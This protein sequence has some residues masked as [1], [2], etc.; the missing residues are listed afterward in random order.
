[1]S[2]RLQKIII[3]TVL[4]IVLFL[5]LLYIAFNSS[6]VQTKLTQSIGNYFGEKWN[7]TVSLD[8]IHL[9][10]F[11]RLSLREVYIEDLHGDTMIYASEIYINFN[12]VNFFK[13]VYS[14]KDLRLNDAR[15]YLK[16][17]KG[18]DELNLA[19]LIKAFSSDQNK[20]TSKVKEPFRLSLDDVE[21]NRTHFIFQNQNKVDTGYGIHYADLD[22]SGIN[23]LLSHISIIDDSIHFHIESLNAKEKSG[24]FLEDIITQ[25]Y[26]NGKGFDLKP[27][28]INMNNSYI[29]ANR[30]AFEYGEWGNFVDFIDKV[31]MIGDFNIA[32]ILMDDIAYFAPALVGWE[33]EFKLEGKI[34]GKVNNLSGRRI[35]IKTGN[36]TSFHGNFNIDGLPD[37]KTS[38]ITVEANKLYSDLEDLENIQ[39]YPFKEGKKIQLPE[40][41][42]EVGDFTFKG[43]FT[44]FLNDF[45]SYGV[46][47]SK[48]GNIKS[49]VSLKQL[50]NDELLFSGRLKAKELDLGTIIGNSIL[51][52]LDCNLEAE[53]RMRDGKFISATLDGVI[54]RIGANNYDY[55]NIELNGKLHPEDFVG[56]MT[57]DDPALNLDFKGII[58]LS[59]DSI[60]LDFNTDL[61]YADLGALKVLPIKH[62]SSLSGK[63]KMDFIGK[64]WTGL[65]GKMNIQG[66][67]FCTDNSDFEFGNISLKNDTLANSK[68]LILES[69]IIS[70]Q[71]AGNYNIS[72]ISKDIIWEVS[73]AIPSYL[74]YDSNYVSQQDFEYNFVFH[75]IS[76]LQE[77]GIFD[78]DLTP[79]SQ[80]FGKISPNTHGTSV[81]LLSDSLYL[82]GI[83]WE[84]PAL[85]LE[86]IKGEISLDLVS[87]TIHFKKGPT[88]FQE[89]VLS[90]KIGKD[91]IDFNFNWLQI[92]DERGEFNLQAVFSDSLR[93][94]ITSKDSRFSFL[95]KN[96]VISDL[97][98]IHFDSS[99]FS[100]HNIELATELQ[101]IKVN[102]MYGG[103]LED[104][105]QLEVNN[106]ELA[107]FNYIL[108]QFNYKVEG[109]S[110]GYLNWIRDDGALKLEAEL[111]IDSAGINDYYLGD[112]MLLSQKSSLDSSY[113]IKIS[114]LD[115]TFEKLKIE[116]S[117]TPESADE[118]MD[119]TIDFNEFDLKVLNYTNLPGISDIGGFTKGAVRLVGSFQKPRLKGKIDIREGSFF[120]DV[121]G[122]NFNFNNTIDIYED[123][124][125]LDP[126]YMYDPKGQKALAY[127]TVL[128]ENLK[129]W[130]YDLSVDLDQFMVMNLKNN[131]D[132]LFYGKAYA[133]G[134][135][136]IWGYNKLLFIDVDATTNEETEIYI[137]IKKSNSVDRQ[138]FIEF[139]NRDSAS[140]ASL[141][142]IPIIDISGVD[143]NLDIKVTPDALVELVFNE[144]TGDILNVRA[145]GNLNLKIDKSGFAMIGS[146]ETYEGEYV[147]TFESIINKHFVI[148]QGSKISWL[149]NPYDA[150]I[151]I[152]ALYQTRASLAPI[153]I[154]EEE[155]YKSRVNTQVFL[156]LDGNL[157]SPTI[158]FEIELP[159]S[160]ER[161]R[162]ALRSATSTTEDLNKQVVSLLLLNSFQSI[163][164][165]DESG[166]LATS[167]TF[168]LLSNQVSTWLSQISEGVDVN[169]HYRPSSNTTGQEFD[170]GAS[171]DVLDDR[172]TI[173]TQLGFKEIT[174]TETANNIVGDFIIE[175]KLTKDGRV[176][177]KGFNKSNDNS[178]LQFYQAPYTQ[179]IGII[180]RKDFDNKMKR[181]PSD[182]EDLKQKF[183]KDNLKDKVKE[184]DEG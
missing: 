37:I 17:Y 48:R 28:T 45:V 163:S 154:G 142:E 148:P 46:L 157:Q 176:R 116:G 174:T 169:V 161:E 167:N 101:N 63:I 36:K 31:N 175:Y 66:L 162:T 42:K 90:S 71:I 16:T 131:K 120:L 59:N 171:F 72:T 77:L 115:E 134:T 83:Q 23:A 92:D 91:T 38:F 35:S 39:L 56:E 179:G 110:N 50:D 22:V 133:T 180:F 88:Y 27:L 97:G 40:S 3:R 104:T 100:F 164:G 25:G 2:L 76:F 136:N 60:I 1:M 114:L 126:F 128:H 149:G 47:T 184:D 33:Q 121:L 135:A 118:L 57:I 49:D 151:D 87:E 81:N 183:E 153:M 111:E 112:I 69:D 14:I 4:G 79:E 159:D 32:Q 177:L 139:I 34:T 138:E 75:D 6:Y 41:V 107:N 24:V 103:V 123:Y 150:N 20:D 12:T 144:A 122:I 21:I 166:G 58:N 158:S 19:F 85:H 168:E 129:N 73:Q 52:K 18:E 173:T 119:L 86:A 165:W 146:L 117:L 125:A 43:D 141:E 78:I 147:F 65:L 64:E 145:E 29:D 9:E 84:S 61:L 10:P 124:I 26:I 140:I 99:Y 13:G 74:N 94:E 113:H 95:E 70:G 67:A 51:G 132:A 178:E 54:D 105:L 11:K 181:K 127:G 130:N 15:F 44:G 155:E 160:K 102:G 182:K 80:L 7:T 82:F 96:W 68:K 5:M 53:L 152:T 172:I 89:N 62:Y 8:R 55:R 109:W 156:N 170:V 93:F 143:M 30:L 137:P 98:K 106:F 108:Q